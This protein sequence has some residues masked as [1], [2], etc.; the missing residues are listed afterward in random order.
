MVRPSD[1]LVCQPDSFP[2]SSLIGQPTPIECEAGVPRDTLK[3]VPKFPSSE[4]P[5][6]RELQVP[7]FQV[8]RTS[9]SEIKLNKNLFFLFHQKTFWRLPFAFPRIIDCRAAC[10]NGTKCAFLDRA[11]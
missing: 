4:V 11:Y 10:M 9:S 6:F 1:G 2:P 7:N 5:K 8:P 3:Q